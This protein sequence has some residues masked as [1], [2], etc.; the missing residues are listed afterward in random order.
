MVSDLTVWTI[1]VNT[2]SPEFAFVYQHEY[3]PHKWNQFFFTWIVRVISALSQEEAWRAVLTPLLE[4]WTAAPGL[5]DNLM[6]S[7]L[8]QYVKIEESLNPATVEVWKSLC[9]RILESAELARWANASY[10]ESSRREVVR[11]IVFAWLPREWPHAALFPEILDKWV[12]VIGHN[13]DAYPSMLTFL[14]GP[15]RVFSPEP[16]LE[17]I[18]RC[19]A[20]SSRDQQFWQVHRNAERT[21]EF[22]QRAWDADE[23]E[24]RRQPATLKSYI[25]LVDQL[26]GA[27]VPLA[28]VLQMNLELREE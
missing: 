21:A 14:H 11:H 1:A 23:E 6:Y 24:I 13:P 2:S 10:L 26:V 15:G 28:S 5:L 25:E 18:S 7:Y 8:E 17:W 9:M 20:A 4:Q 12:T 22:L 16:A 27:G 3:P 19:V